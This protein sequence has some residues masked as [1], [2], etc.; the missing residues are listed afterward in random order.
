M[1]KSRPSTLDE[2]ILNVYEAA[3]DRTHWP[4]A[5]SRLSALTRSNFSNF[6][7]VDK[8]RATAVFS[9]A[10]ATIPDKTNE[11]YIGHFSAIDPR[12]ALARRLEPGHVLTC[13]QHFDAPYVT[14][15]EFYQDFL[16]PFGGRYLACAK[17]MDD[18]HLNAVIGFHRNA[19]AGPFDRENL[20]TIGKVIPH[21]SQAALLFRRVSELNEENARLSNALDRMPWGIIKVDDKAHVLSCNKSAEAMLNRQ[22]G[23]RIRQGCIQTLFIEQTSALLKLVSNAASAAVGKVLEA[24]R[25]LRIDKTTGGHLL[26]LVL[27]GLERLQ[28]LEH[29]YRGAP[30]FVSDS[31]DQPFAPETILRQLFKLTRA[32]ATVAVAISQGLTL[33]DIAQAHDV[34]LTT[35]RTQ[36][37]AILEKTGTSRQAELVHR[38]MSLPKAR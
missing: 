23:I 22:D 27:P 37:R 17:I 30:L 12:L 13:D 31:A 8:Q 36:T 3:N 38:I 14:R 19:G 7:L 20:K 2:V 5:L 34:S 29:P 21:L 11:E 26:A 6:V 1:S 32:E 16:I 28:L 15:S 9:T 25:P 35:V 4:T 10:D 24:G 33:D 18:Q